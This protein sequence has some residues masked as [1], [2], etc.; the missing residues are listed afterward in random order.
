MKYFAKYL[1]IEGECKI[2][3]LTNQGIILERMSQ[4]KDRV[5]YITDTKINGKWTN[6]EDDAFDSGELYLIQ[7]FLCSRDIREGDN[8]QWQDGDG[9]I[10]HGIKITIVSPDAY[11]VIGPISPEATWV[12]EGDQ[13]EEEQIKRDILTKWYS[14]EDDYTEYVHYH[15]KGDREFVVSEEDEFICEYPI[16]VQCS[17]CKTFH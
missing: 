7:L 8:Y 4:I 1:K 10:S 3:S 16:K 9:N 11:K 14:G 17:L 5:V 15:P 13:F 12:K 2:G 6:K